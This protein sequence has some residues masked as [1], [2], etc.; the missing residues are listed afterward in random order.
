MPEA[1][2]KEERAERQVL[3]SEARAKAYPRPP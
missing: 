1:S 2:S 3:L